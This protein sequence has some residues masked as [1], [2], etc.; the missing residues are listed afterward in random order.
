M[1]AVLKGDMREVLAQLPANSID[2]VV[3]DPPY[4]YDFLGK[5]WDNTGIAFDPKAWAEVLRV[6]KPGGYLIAFGATRTHHRIWCAIEDAGFEIRDTIP[7]LF[8]QGYPGGR[9]VAK[10]VDAVDRVGA[11]RERALRFTAW[12]REVGLN[13]T[14]INKLTGTNMGSHYVT[15]QSQPE[16]ATRAMFELLRPE[17]ERRGHTVPEWVEELV[18]ARTV[19]S[20]NMKRRKAKGEKR[21][22]SSRPGMPHVEEVGDVIDYQPTEAFTE[23]AKAWEGWWTRL[24]PGNEPICIAR[25]PLEGTIADNVLKYGVGGLNIDATRVAAPEGDREDYGLANAPVG[26][27]TGT[28]YGAWEATRTPY[29]RPEGGR[30]TPNVLLGHAGACVPGRCV[31]GCPVPAIDAMGGGSKKAGKAIRRNSKGEAG[32]Q[33]LTLGVRDGEDVGYGDEGGASRFFPAF[34]A[35][36]ASTAEREAGCEHLVGTH[37][38][39]EGKPLLD[40]KGRPLKRGNIHPTVKPMALMQWLVW[41]VTPRWGVVLDPFTG[42][43]ST[44]VAVAAE[45]TMGWS[46]VGIELAA[47][48]KYDEIAAGRIAHAANGPLVR[49]VQKVAALL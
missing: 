13:S 25:K 17:I 47:E 39:A 12:I 30:W 43:G 31:F 46:F 45:K 18:N 20:E 42:S 9:D 49:D 10:A 11:S 27:L 35:P 14:V 41:L 19:E 37:V 15:A 1:Y 29:H 34:Y 16:V 40:D 26:G 8:G 6:L 24:K 7:W 38:D 4:E 3:C 32:G 23:A 33:V 5:G 28:V 22:V 48:A 2:S 44:G 36:K 21:K